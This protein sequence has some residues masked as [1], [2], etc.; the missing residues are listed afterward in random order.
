LN[1]S[2]GHL[3][4]V[5]PFPRAVN[6]TTRR[7]FPGQTSG[8]QRHSRP[9]THGSPRESMA[10]YPAWETKTHIAAKRKSQKRKRLPQRQRIRPLRVG[11]RHHRPRPLRSPSSILATFFP[12]RTSIPTEQESFA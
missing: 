3:T 1:F 9:K 11:F 5:N 4:N 12:V 6:I 2:G 10:S 7:R 8:L